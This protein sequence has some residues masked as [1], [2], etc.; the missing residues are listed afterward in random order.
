MGKLDSLGFV[1]QPVK[2]KE[3]SYF[4]PITLLIELPAEV[5]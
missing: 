3:N 5:E 4:R 2:E 1:V